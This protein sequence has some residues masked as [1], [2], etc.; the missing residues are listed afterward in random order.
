MPAPRPTVAATGT[1]TSRAFSPGLRS[2]SVA[3]AYARP[4]FVPD[5]LYS[6]RS[7]ERCAASRLTR[8]VRAP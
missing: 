6:S 8:I 7:F 1:A 5:A 4:T 2:G 3:Q